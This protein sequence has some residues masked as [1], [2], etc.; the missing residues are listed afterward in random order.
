MTKCW[1]DQS[2][3]GLVQVQLLQKCRQERLHSSSAKSPSFLHICL[4]VELLHHALILFF[5][6]GKLPHVPW[7]SSGILHSH[8]S[9]HDVFW[10]QYLWAFTPP[11]LL[12]T[13]L[14]GTGGQVLELW[15]V[16]DFKED[17]F[18]FFFFC[19]PLVCLLG[20]NFSL[21]PLHIYILCNYFIV[22]VVL[23]E[24]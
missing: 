12:T 24:N 22:A 9:A 5:I 10:P 6:F 8:Q 1:R 4:K 2:Y 14:M 16:D 19:W 7:S 18:F 17:G 21:W 3:A 13:I 11:C 15:F 23:W 20:R